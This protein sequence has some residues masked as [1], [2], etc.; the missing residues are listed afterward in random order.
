MLTDNKQI[1]IKI[2]PVTSSY[3]HANKKRIAEVQINRTIGSSLT[4]VNKINSRPDEQKAIM[5]DVI[6]IAGNSAE[7]NKAIKDYWNSFTYEVPESGKSL[8]VGFLYDISSSDSIISKFINSVNSNIS[9][10]SKH[11]TTD[12]N[13]KEYIDSRLIKINSDFKRRMQEIGSIKDLVLRDK[14]ETQ[15]FTNK[16]NNIVSIEGDRYKVGRPINAF[17]YILYRYCLGYAHVANEEILVT[18]SPNIRFYLYS[19]DDIKKDKKARQTTNRTRMATLLKVTESV[20]S[21]ENLLYAMNE[22]DNMPSDDGDKYEKVETLSKTRTED[23]LK[24]ANDKNLISIGTIEKYIKYG[25][26]SRSAGSQVIYNP[27]SDSNDPIAN[28]MEEGIRYFL[29]AANKAIISNLETRYKN[30]S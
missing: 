28:N 25:I 14:L 23:F 9:D 18:K 5:S 27:T 8:E 22:A 19:D 26:L 2:R 17:E 20:S 24:V 12:E 7:W 29:N 13:L 16:Y 6:G 30:Q 1:H 4:S 10:K 15:A 21:I 3:A 11:L